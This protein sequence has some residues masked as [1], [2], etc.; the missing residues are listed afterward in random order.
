MK[1]KNRKKQ[2]DEEEQKNERKILIKKYWEE[3]NKIYE[4]N[5]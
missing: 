5:E 3:I 2:V 1:G 4:K